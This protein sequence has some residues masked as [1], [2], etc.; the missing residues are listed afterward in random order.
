MLTKDF[1]FNLPEELIAQVPT[2]ERGTSRMLVLD[3]PAA[4]PPQLAHM[5]IRDIAD[6]LPAGTVMIVNN[7]KVRRA[8]LNAE[9]A[10]GGSVE[11]LLLRR[12][13][14]SATEWEIMTSKSKRRKEG[15]ILYLPDN[16]KLTI[17]GKTT[18]G[19][20][21]AEAHPAID[22]TYLEVHGRVPLPP[23]IK[24]MHQEVDLDRYQTVYAETTGSVAAPTAGLHFTPEILSELVD[25]GIHIH[26]IT[27]HVGL[28]TF[29]PVRSEH[30]TDH[31]MHRE[32]YTISP[33]TAAAVERARTEGRPVLA[34]GTT[35]V[36]A[37]E[38]SWNDGRL[39][40]GPQS[41]EIFIYPGYRFNSLD[42]LLTNF[43]TPESTLLMLVS[44]L[45]GKEHIFHAYQEAIAKKYRFFSY[46]DAMLINTWNRPLLQNQHGPA[47]TGQD[48]DR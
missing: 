2:H 5:H 17:T 16:L 31:Q 14:R 8:R 6:L 47:P 43:H 24:R 44:A 29:L 45:A 25:K 40:T 37:L 11:V 38:S 46:G 36:R 21:T 15:E 30:I 33:E 27:L 39:Q 10:H 19:T 28:G 1:Y 4:H 3:T 32:E 13:G 7:S 12:S 23:Y 48:G 20:W 22:D 35:S 34:V 41:T 9:T 42:M 18:E 26:A